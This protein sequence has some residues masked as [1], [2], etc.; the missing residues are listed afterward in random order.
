MDHSIKKNQSEGRDHNGSYQGGYNEYLRH[1]LKSHGKH[2]RPRPNYGVPKS[3]HGP[4]KGQY[5][6]YKPNNKAPP[7][8]GYSQSAYNPPSYSSYS[9]YSPPEYS[10]PDYSSSEYS[11][12]SY[13]PH[14]YSSP[15]YNPP[16]PYS[17]P[18]ATSYDPTA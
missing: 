15:V 2:K 16:A 3:Q 11:S 5:G 14:S 13:S 1:P 18:Y 8:P 10:H 7:F 12:A 9:D 4:P 6:A 17:P